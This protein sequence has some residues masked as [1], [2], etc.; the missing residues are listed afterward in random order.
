MADKVQLL[1]PILYFVDYLPNVLLLTLLYIHIYVVWK[2]QE[3]C[4]IT[5]S[6][7]YCLLLSMLIGI[8]FYSYF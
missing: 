6:K 7:R 2:H 8:L 4:L 5:M 3:V 1:F